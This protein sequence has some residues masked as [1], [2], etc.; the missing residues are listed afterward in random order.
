M[1]LFRGNK[2]LL[3]TNLQYY[4]RL[5]QRQM[6]HRE[7]FIGSSYYLIMYTIASFLGASLKGKERKHVFS[8]NSKNKNYIE[9]VY[10]IRTEN[11]ISKYILISYLI[12][13]PLLSYKYPSIDVFREL[14]QISLARVREKKKN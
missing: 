11:F 1:A 14:L 2:G 13:Y 3:P 6:Y 9:Y 4:M 7:S 8:D 5:S 10:L 12:K